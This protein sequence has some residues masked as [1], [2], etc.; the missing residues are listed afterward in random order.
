MNNQR[1][2]ITCGC[3]GSFNAY[4]LGGGHEGRTMQ[5]SFTAESCAPGVVAH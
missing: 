4:G 1:A 2:Q 5:A 3:S